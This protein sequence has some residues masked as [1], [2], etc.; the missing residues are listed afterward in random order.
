MSGVM[1]AEAG[2]VAVVRKK[3]EKLEH[4]CMERYQAREQRVL[5]TLSYCMTALEQLQSWAV[6]AIFPT[7]EQN[8]DKYV[9]FVEQRFQCVIQPLRI[10]QSALQR[11]AGS[12]SGSGI[13][14]G[15]A[16]YGGSGTGAHASDTGSL[17]SRGSSPRDFA[18]PRSHSSDSRSPAR[19]RSPV[20]A[21][22]RGMSPHPPDHFR[23]GSSSDSG[24][25][26]DTSRSHAGSTLRDR[27]NNISQQYLEEGHF[28]K[29]IVLHRL[30]KCRKD[31][32]TIY[33]WGQ[34]SL[35]DLHDV[36]DEAVADELYFLVRG[37]MQRVLSTISAFE[38]AAELIEKNLTQ[39]Q[40]G[41]GGGGV[42][43]ETPPESDAGY[44]GLEGFDLRL[45][46]QSKEGEDVGYGD[47]GPADRRLFL[48]DMTGDQGHVPRVGSYSARETSTFLSARGTDGDDMRTYIDSN[49]EAGSTPEPPS[50]PRPKG[51]VNHPKIMQDKL[52]SFAL[53]SKFNGLRL[54]T[55]W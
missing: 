18:S 28:V 43:G 1:G 20:E 46:L 27:T 19:S 36:I 35:L 8:S 26:N 15:H 23:S 29:R 50:S 5:S 40:N 3:F 12:G 13:E 45:D 6:F 49:S 41:G 55:T 53:P 51:L 22:P 33:R 16:G 17:S 39:L 42:A 32:R 37:K 38:E 2:L 31:L 10:F 30:Q 7:D 34:A 48:D 25:G 9:T 21:L 4:T 14:R 24:L 54:S 47:L 52:R 44:N 11:E